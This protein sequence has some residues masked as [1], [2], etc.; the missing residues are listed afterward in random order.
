MATASKEIR[1]LIAA[2]SGGTVLLPGSVVA[3]VIDFS[4][5]KPYQDA[6]IW[7]LGEVGWSDWSVPV[8]SFARLA[9]TS[10]KEVPDK[11]S[12]ILVVKSL[13]ESSSAPYLG[14]LISGVPRMAKVRSASLSKPKRLADFPTAPELPLA[15][16][17]SAIEKPKFF[18]RR[19][20]IDV[21]LWSAL[22]AKAGERGLTSAALLLTAYS[23]VLSR[24]SRNDQVVINIPLFNRLPLHPQVNDVVG[25]FTSVNL[26]A[27]DNS[28]PD[29]FVNR[30]KRLQAQLLDDLDHR[31]FDGVEV[32][33]ELARVKKSQIKGG[34]YPRIATRQAP[35]GRKG[36]GPFEPER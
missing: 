31:H 20:V 11:R 30:A 15:K 18:R 22:K 4:S 24:W 2:I 7:L 3:E 5:P 17:P 12:R 23:E 25:A 19:Q 13:A 36:R 32:M 1:T 8:V 10:D 35:C 34:T 9:G 14:I 27:A 21:K 16:H 29:S 33:R 6:P 26:L 28:L